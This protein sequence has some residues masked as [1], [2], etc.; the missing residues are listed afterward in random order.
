ML[1]FFKRRKYRKLGNALL[2]SAE[3]VDLYRRDLIAPD[4]LR[5]QRELA[6]ALRRQLKQPFVQEAW[7]KDMHA[8]HDVLVK[9]GGKIYPVTTGTD[10]TE[11]VIM[12]AIVAPRKAS[13]DT[14]RLM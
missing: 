12:A 6:E 11:M 9:N 10:Y 5:E 7:D 1:G 3:K 8:L 14:K 2:E 13:N 4:A